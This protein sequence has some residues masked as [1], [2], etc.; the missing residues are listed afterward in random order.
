MNTDPTIA[1]GIANFLDRVAEHLVSKTP[2][3]RREILADLE[4][5]IYEALASRAAGRQPAA[6]VLKAV[7]AE[8]DPPES[9]GQS[10]QANQPSLSSKR[11]IGIIA[12][13]TCLGSLVVAG[14]LGMLTWHG[15]AIWIPCF[16]FL[17]GQITALVLGIISWSDPFG[18]AAAITSGVLIA[19][20]IILLIVCLA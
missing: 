15:L 3:Q 5:H 12:L 16:L 1:Q 8:M 20:S 7:L 17:A 19:L 14:L 11:I 18:K 6:D 2:A 9:Y 13:C 10:S 4:S